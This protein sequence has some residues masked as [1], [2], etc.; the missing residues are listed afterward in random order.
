MGAA[1][2][3]RGRDAETLAKAELRRAV[4]T[5]Q[6]RRETACPSVCPACA[7][8]GSGPGWDVALVR[9]SDDLPR[10]AWIFIKMSYRL[11][12]L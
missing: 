3:D 12:T 10:P 7:F 8:A 4:P 5:H 9:A 1:Y 2:G 11:C 6:C